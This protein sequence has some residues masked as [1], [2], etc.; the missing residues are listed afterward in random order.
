MFLSQELYKTIGKHRYYVLIHNSS[1]FTVMKR[2]TKII[3]CFGVTTANG[4]VLKCCSI[5]KAENHCIRE[6][7]KT[8]QTQAGGFG[9]KRR[10]MPLGLDILREKI[11]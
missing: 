3:L 10:R 11:K 9:E 2:T 6:P 5:R 8:R 4:P 1:K 7:R